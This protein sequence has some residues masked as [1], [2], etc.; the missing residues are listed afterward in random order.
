MPLMFNPCQP[1][2]ES[3]KYSVVFNLEWTGTA[4][5]E[6][7]AVDDTRF[8]SNYPFE[9]YP[10]C[11]RGN[12]NYGGLS[13]SGGNPS[14]SPGNH[15]IQISGVFSQTTELSYWYNQPSNSAPQTYATAF[16]VTVT[17]LCPKMFTNPFPNPSSAYI[18]QG[19]SF[20]MPANEPGYFGY[21]TGFRNDAYNR[22]GYFPA[23]ILGSCLNIVTVA[24]EQIGSG[25][26]I[27]A[28]NQLFTNDSFYA[29]GAIGRG[30]TTRAGAGFSGP[31]ESGLLKKIYS[32]ANGSWG[33]PGPTGAFA[34]YY[35][36]SPSVPNVNNA[37]ALSTIGGL[38]VGDI[39]YGNGQ[40]TPTGIAPDIYNWISNGGVLLCMS[41][42]DG[43][44]QTYPD[45]NL[46]TKQLGSNMYF[47]PESIAS[48][49]F[50][51]NQNSSIGSGVKI[52]TSS[53][54]GTYLGQGINNP[55]DEVVSF[56]QIN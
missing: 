33:C 19:Q 10:S 25:Y 9:T 11:Y 42:V 23:F 27:M 54:D 47:N 8:D 29:T 13:Y 14:L 52:N 41:Y 31:P 48:G 36:M 44:A 39:S 15:S 51:L 35:P 38:Q 4:D 46:L 40:I 3:C 45:I 56:V 12:P 20:T 28:N 37:A 7:Y 24:S 53:S 30:I 43:Y 49:V 34:D 1:C 32:L 21:N 18:Y 17:V 16:N 22:G 26:I 5:L 2:C 55:V 6:L 50:Y